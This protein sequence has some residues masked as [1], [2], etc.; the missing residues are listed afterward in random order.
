MTSYTHPLDEPTYDHEF[1]TKVWYLAHPLAPDDKFTFQEN[2]DHALKMMR[3]CFEQ[4]FYNIAP[5]HTMVC[6]WGGGVEPPEQRIRALE[7]D[8]FVAHSLGRIIL[9]GHKRSRGM[10]AEYD[11]VCRRV[12]E[13]NDQYIKSY[14]LQVNINDVVIDLTSMNDE[15]AIEHLQHRAIR[16]NTGKHLG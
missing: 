9:T 14:H 2:M 12:K 11:A 8:C 15:L 6:A 7:T 13:W 10:L 16:L 4:G 1:K 3:I 5:W